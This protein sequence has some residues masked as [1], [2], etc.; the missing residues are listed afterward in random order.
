M[1]RKSADRAS[2]PG[3]GAHPMIA[4]ARAS[5]NGRTLCSGR[6]GENPSIWSCHLFALQDLSAIELDSPTRRRTPPLAFKFK[7]GLSGGYAPDLGGARIR[8]EA[9]HLAGGQI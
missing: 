3:E 8:A 2:E 7:E 5:H 6:V 1:R 4:L 9:A